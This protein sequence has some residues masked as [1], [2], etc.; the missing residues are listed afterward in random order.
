MIKKIVRFDWAMKKILRPKANFDVL[1]GFLSEPLG[2][3]V[4]IKQVL[5]SESN[6]ETVDDKF[7][8]VGILVENEKDE[9]V[10]IEVPMARASPL[11]TTITR[12][13]AFFRNLG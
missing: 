13:P 7:N 12:L 4:K 3:D 10:I 5:D 2:E 9:L 6:K 11:V 8:R 1:E